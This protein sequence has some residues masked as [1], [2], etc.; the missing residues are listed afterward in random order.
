MTSLLT[1][2]PSSVSQNDAFCGQCGAPLQGDDRACRQCGAPTLL[3]VSEP[4][5]GTPDDRKRS[6][7]TGEEAGWENTKAVIVG[8]LVAGLV[9]I[10]LI[11]VVVA[12]SRGGEREIS[13]E[14]L[15]WAGG[16]W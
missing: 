13:V 6:L 12:L 7:S 11:A 8:V 3:S 1:P 14:L 10:V 16:W 9:V 2:S 4:Q 15:P 5:H